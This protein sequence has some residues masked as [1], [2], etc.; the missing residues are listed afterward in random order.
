M[1]AKQKSSAKDANDLLRLRG[2]K[3]VR[4]C[5]AAAKKPEPATAPGGTRAAAEDPQTP[6]V[7]IRPGDDGRA[8]RLARHL[9]DRVLYVRE[10][11]Q[12]LIYTG[13]VYVPDVAG[14]RLLTETEG[15]TKEILSEAAD[16]GDADQ[17]KR[18]LDEAKAA[19][20]LRGKKAMCELLRAQAGVSVDANVLDAD[21]MLLTFAN[22][23]LHLG[24]LEFRPHSPADRLTKIL[25]FPYQPGTACPLLERFVAQVW[26]D[27]D[28]QLFMQR[29][30]GYC[31]CG[32]TTEQ[33]FVFLFGTGGNGK[34]VFARI[35]K[36]LLGPYC[37]QS[38][39]SMLL[40][41]RDSR[42]AAAPELCDLRGAR[43]SICSE[44]PPGAYINASVIS[45]ATGEDML[46]ARRLFQE[47]QT[48]QP[49]H[50]FLVLGNHKLK[51]RGISEAIRRRL[52]LVDCGQKFE[53]RR[54][55]THLYEKLLAELP[56]IANWAIQGFQQ[57]QKTG[58]DVPES[59]RA[60]GDDFARENDPLADF[61][62]RGCDLDAGVA[63]TR[64]D[65]FLHYQVFCAK[66]GIA[67]PLSPQNFSAQLV[68]HGVR[69]GGKKRIDRECE[70]MW[71]GIRP[72]PI[73]ADPS[74]SDRSR[75]SVFAGG[76]KCK[77]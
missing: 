70:R 3:R 20:S 46:T 48:W 40:E 13:K 45:V 31:L 65:L 75:L 47:N 15:V 37:V 14:D 30:A 10:F 25:D 18:L 41:S 69:D 35:L 67:Y 71:Q 28:V 58:L 50:K 22:G 59:I 34:G 29:Y 62:E 23:V 54:C 49:T 24:N 43:L 8:K 61:I 26:P 74:A 2:R 33:K 60:A 63:C 32:L 1:S 55:D 7:Q 11:R 57:W 38:P 39:I 44:P 17:R 4:K 53:G 9:G 56:G 72:R 12:Y 5:F 36:A 42:S 66:N 6:Q 76:K 73:T 68:E 64:S 77:F 52:C 16:A 21:P 27:R 51:T 19:D